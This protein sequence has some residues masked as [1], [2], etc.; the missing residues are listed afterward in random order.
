MSAIIMDGK[1]LAAQIRDTLK[2]EVAEY[3]NQS[4]QPGL[5]VIL[6]GNHP[7]SET[8]VQAKQKAA[9]AVGIR[10]YLIRF[11]DNVS[12]GELLAKIAQLNNDPQVNGILV[13]LPLPK[14]IDVQTVID[15]IDPEKDV[16]GFH[17]LNVGNMQVGKK[18]LLPCTPFGIVKLLKAYNI[19]LQGKHAVIVGHSHIVGRPM[20]TL[21]L[22]ENATVSVCHAY[23][24]NLKEMTKMADILIVAVGKKHLITGDMV[25]PAA[26]VIDVGINRE[27]KRIFGDCDFDSIKDI[28]S[29]ITPVP[30]GVG[31]MTIATLLCNTL[32]AARSQSKQPVLV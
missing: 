10:S 12:Q 14:H 22:N 2:D 6:V 17:P 1:Q 8:Y 29:H 27:G 23:T 5:A 3:Q 21:L 19:P 20:A 25:K 13:Q 31:P 26:T 9:L 4:V 11:A 32:Q 28:A 18:T 30:G 16:D 24:E 15:A 7:A